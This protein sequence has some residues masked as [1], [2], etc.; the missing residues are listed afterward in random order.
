MCWRIKQKAV[1]ILNVYILPDNVQSHDKPGH[2]YANFVY[3]RILGISIG[4]FLAMIEFS[5]FVY[6]GLHV[7][8]GL[9]QEACLWQSI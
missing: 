2:D 3:P 8:A 4:V 6:K 1:D 7:L 9:V 5:S